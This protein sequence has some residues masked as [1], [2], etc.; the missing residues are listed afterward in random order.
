VCFLPSTFSE[1]HH[2]L[3][4]QPSVLDSLS[5]WQRHSISHTLRKKYHSRPSLNL[6]GPIKSVVI[7]W[8]RSC[9]LIIFPGFL[10]GT[11]KGPVVVWFKVF[12]GISLQETMNLSQESWYPGRYSKYIR[13]PISNYPSKW[14]GLSDI[15]YCLT[16]S[17][18]GVESPTLKP[19]MDYHYFTAFGG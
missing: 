7:Y 10:K 1:I 2:S 17:M 19:K 6:I 16:C 15:S 14:D 8:S 18:C 12:P 13:P 9:S 5:H 4:P 11:W 3:S